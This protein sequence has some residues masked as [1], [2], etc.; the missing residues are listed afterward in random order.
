MAVNYSD[1]QKE[2]FIRQWNEATDRLRGSTKR[3]PVRSD[4]GS[5]GR[6]FGRKARHGEKIRRMQVDD[7]ERLC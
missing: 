3:K 4:D 5:Q 2:E 6:T 7:H 1:Q